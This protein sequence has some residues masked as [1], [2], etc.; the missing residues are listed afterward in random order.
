ME[1]HS[2]LTVERQKG[3]LCYRMSGVYSRDLVTG[4]PIRTKQRNNTFSVS[5]SRI[6]LFLS[7]CQP[8]ALPVLPV[9]NN[10][11]Y[12]FFF[13][14][15]FTAFPFIC[16]ICFCLLRISFPFPPHFLGIQTRALLFNQI[17]NFV[18]LIRNPYI[19]DMIV[20]TCEAVS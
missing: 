16:F 1:I 4:K 14:I 20:E 17:L 9:A 2:I 19:A 13:F 8:Q 15:F 3:L 10:Q 18:N 5:Y 11:R 7:L 6:T 12:L